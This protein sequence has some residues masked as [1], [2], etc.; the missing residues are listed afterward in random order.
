M[1]G[2]WLSRVT[3]GVFLETTSAINIEEDLLQTEKERD[4]LEEVMGLKEKYREVILLYYYQEMAIKDI[5]EVLNIK[6]GSVGVRLQR[7]R[8]QLGGKLQEVSEYE[9]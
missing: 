5:A 8:E 2:S 7:A 1:R 6:E 3:T 4:L 9:R